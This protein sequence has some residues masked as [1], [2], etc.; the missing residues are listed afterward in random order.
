MGQASGLSQ[1]NKTYNFRL[2]K[3]VLRKPGG[4]C[5]KAIDEAF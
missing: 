1:F 3:L 2:S 5:A 4:S